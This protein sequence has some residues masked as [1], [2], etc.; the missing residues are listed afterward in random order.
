V[1]NR[2]ALIIVILIGLTAVLA[3]GRFSKLANSGSDTGSDE[4][5]TLDPRAGAFTLAGKEW[6]SFELAQTDIKV[7]LPGRP[8][9]KSPEMPQNARTIFSAMRI[10]AY[11]DKDFASSFTEL[12]PT[13]SRKFEIKYLADTSMAALKKQIRDLTYTLDIRS[14]TNAKYTGSF[15]RNGKNYDLRGC[16]VYKKGNPARV[17]AILTLSPKDNADAQTAG[18]RIIDSVVFK[19]SSEECR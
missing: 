18:Q 6:T 2:S 9:D 14:E 4:P 15:T 16:C 3:C 7:D 5:K 11:D 19:D 8:S 17:W 12:V 10:H 13:G 1:K